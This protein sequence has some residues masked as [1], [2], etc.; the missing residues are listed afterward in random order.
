[1]QVLKKLDQ[2]IVEISGTIPQA[3]KGF[4]GF[5]AVSRPAQLFVELLRGLLIQKG[6]VI[7]GQNKLVNARIKRLLPSLLQ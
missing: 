3:I 6:V 4:Q 5:I 7:T 2:N 1:V